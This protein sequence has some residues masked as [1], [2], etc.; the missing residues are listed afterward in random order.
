MK[1]G[2]EQHQQAAEHGASHEDAPS[3]SPISRISGVSKLL[4]VVSILLMGAGIALPFAIGKSADTQPM[5]QPGESTGEFDNNNL[6]P[7]F[8]PTESTGTGEPSSLETAKDTATEWSPAMFRA[9][10]SFFAGFSIAMALKLVLRTALVFAGFFLLGLFGLQYAGIADIDWTLLGNKY[11]TVSAW[12]S[13]QF[14][15]AK[16]FITGYMPS[17]AA[18]LGGMFM[19]FRSR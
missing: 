16:G 12:A 5:Q 13:S 19:G 3:G 17:A 6:V 18:T 15:S 1:K 4:L 9:G 7:G 8:A 11:D 10:F 2:K 14:D